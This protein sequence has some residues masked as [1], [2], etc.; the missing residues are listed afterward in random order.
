MKRIFCLAIFAVGLSAC[1]QFNEDLVCE[2]QK[3]DEQAQIS[4]LEFSCAE[5]FKSIL[6]EMSDEDKELTSII[7]T[8]AVTSSSNDNSK[9]INLL[10]PYKQLSIDHDPILNV[11][12]KQ[13]DN[14][15][16]IYEDD[17]SLYKARGYDTLIPNVKI[18]KLLNARAEIKIDDTIYKIS[19][20]GTYFYPESRKAFFEENYG[21]FEEEDGIQIDTCTYKLAEDIWRYNTFE[22][23][24]SIDYEEPNLPEEIEGDTT[25]DDESDFV[26]TRAGNTVSINWSKYPVYDADAKTWVGKI[27]QSLFG[28]NKSYTYKLSQKRRLRAKFYY[29]NYVFYS[30]IGALGEMQKKNWIGWSGTKADELYVGWNNIILYSDYSQKPNASL[31]PKNSKP[32]MASADYTNIP[33]MGKKGYVVS[34][35][36][37]DLTQSQIDAIA[38]MSAEQLFNWLKSRLSNSSKLSK[39]EFNTVMFYT[40]TKVITVIPDDGYYETNVEKIRKVF[41]SDFH[42]ML[43]L[44]LAKIPSSETAWLKWAKSVCENSMEMQRAELKRGEVRVAGRLGDTWGAIRIKKR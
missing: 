22:I 24:E 1:Q 34:I 36:G 11:D 23:T 19:P 13:I 9:F 29:Y 30:E 14:S 37:L 39:S 16:L 28:R 6:E 40:P 8:R 5:D 10:E 7:K 12:C 42:I 38:G 20:R 21:R 4:M 44:N 43:S 15:L 26:S 25:I 41:D 18:A 3:N 32:I 31:Y 35:L 17:I 33:G 2:T 27:W